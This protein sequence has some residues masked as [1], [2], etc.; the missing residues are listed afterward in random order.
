MIRHIN[1]DAFCARLI[2]QGESQF[3]FSRLHPEPEVQNWT[4]VIGFEKEWQETRGLYDGL[5]RSARE[6]DRIAKLKLELGLPR[7]R[8][9]VGLLHQA[10]RRAF[11]MCKLKGMNDALQKLRGSTIIERG[12]E[13]KRSKLNC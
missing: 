7:D 5:I 11:R 10:Y 9:T 6:L 8:L 1:L 3:V 13:Y 4:E 2:R 12:S